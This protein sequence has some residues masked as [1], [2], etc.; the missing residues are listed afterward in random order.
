MRL[1]K[2]RNIGLKFLV[3][4]VLAGILLYITRAKANPYSITND[5]DFATGLHVT[6]DFRRITIQVTKYVPDQESP[7]DTAIA[8]GYELINASDC[9]TCHAEYKIL[10]A[11]SFSE[12]ASRY[13]TDKAA[14]AKLAAKVIS[15]SVGTWGDKPMPA[16]PELL[17]EDARKMIQYIMNLNTKKDSAK[18][19]PGHLRR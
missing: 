17:H 4:L 13:K 8:E 3:G 5:D 18:L 6:D 15:G 9:Y 11:P 19:L 12:I 10:Q 16:H 2:S 1:Y 7:K 14:I